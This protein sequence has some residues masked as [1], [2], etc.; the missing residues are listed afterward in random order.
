MKY[1]FK[2]TFLKL[3]KAKTCINYQE[4]SMQIRHRR[5]W[6]ISLK[7]REISRSTAYLRTPEICGGRA[8]LLKRSLI[9]GPLSL[10]LKLTIH[11]L[12]VALLL[13][14]GLEE[15][16]MQ[17]TLMHSYLTWTPSS[18]PLIL[19]KLYLRF[20][21]VFRSEITLFLS[22]VTFWMNPTKGNAR[23]AKNLFTT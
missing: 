7:I 19:Q 15:I 6:I 5:L 13:W 11:Q 22:L 1:R 3:K 20:L 14:T 12:L 10:L 16:S 21:M 18:L 9:P 23:L 2:V 8:I 17:P 4:L